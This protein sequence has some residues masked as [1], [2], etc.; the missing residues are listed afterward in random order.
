MRKPL[1]HL[2]MKKS[3]PPFPYTAFLL[4]LAVVVFL[5]LQGNLGPRYLYWILLAGPILFVPWGLGL[6]TD[7]WPASQMLM[8]KLLPFGGILVAVAFCWPPGFPT[9]IFATGWLVITVYLLFWAWRKRATLPL[10]ALLAVLFLNVAAAWALAD[11]LGWQPLSFD[12][13]IVLLTAIHFHYAGFALAV[14][15]ALLPAGKTSK[16]LSWSLLLGVSGVAV[17]ITST[18]L[19]G[20]AW[21][22]VTSVTA[23]VL[24]GWSVAIAQARYAMRSRGVARALLVLGSVALMLGLLLA[25]LYGWRFHHQWAWLTIPWMYATHGVLNSVGFVFFSFVGWTVGR[26]DGLAVWRFDECVRSPG[27]PPRQQAV[28]IDPLIGKKLRKEKHPCS[29]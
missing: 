1:K 24:V 29:D 12:P 20:P 19:N 6:L 27:L 7:Q 11:R 28:R 2:V 23:L 18:Q 5:P 10:A 15:T 21:I 25:L 22:E 3:P 26:L 9:A 13:L 8:R 17:G 16:R 14:L 4:Y